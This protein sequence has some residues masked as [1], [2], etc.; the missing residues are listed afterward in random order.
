MLVVVTKLVISVH[1]LS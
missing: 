1:H